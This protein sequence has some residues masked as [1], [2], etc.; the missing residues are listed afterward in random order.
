MKNTPVTSAIFLAE[1]TWTPFLDEVNDG[2]LPLQPPWDLPLH[3]KHDAISRT[4][5]PTSQNSVI[6]K[7]GEFLFHALG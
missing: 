5:E 1:F 3:N 4:S 7:F 6:A 2:R